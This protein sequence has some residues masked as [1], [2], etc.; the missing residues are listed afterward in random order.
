VLAI[1]GS[2]GPPAANFTGRAAAHG[3]KWKEPLGFVE[4]GERANGEGGGARAV[5][6]TG[7]CARGRGHRAPPDRR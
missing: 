7:E 6:K 2:G 5:L 1:A 4:M 3:G